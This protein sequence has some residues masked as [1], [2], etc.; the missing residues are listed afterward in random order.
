MRNFWVGSSVIFACAFTIHCYS[1]L[2]FVKHIKVNNE[3]DM[4]NIQ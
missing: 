4:K 3:N 1:Q 2:V